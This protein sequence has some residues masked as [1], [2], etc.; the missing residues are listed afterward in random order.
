[1]KLWE[2][3]EKLHTKATLRLNSGE[4][5]VFFWRLYITTATA[6]L[7]AEPAFPCV[8]KTQSTN[9]DETEQED[10]VH[11]GRLRSSRMHLAS[12]LQC[13]PHHTLPIHNPSPGWDGPGVK[14]SWWS[15]ILIAV[16]C[17]ASL[18]DLHLQLCSSLPP[19][20]PSVPLFTI[21]EDVT[22]FSHQREMFT[23][24]SQ[25]YFVQCAFAR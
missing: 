12:P 4:H 7:K 13:F 19:N 22:E 9:D 8:Q 16:Q 25:V 6:S 24:K 2:G 1:M 20:F 14:G 23:V 21:F 5:K 18:P 3:W 11:P 10:P 15:C 17:F